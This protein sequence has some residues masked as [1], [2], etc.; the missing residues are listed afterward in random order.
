MLNSS[1]RFAAVVESA[2]RIMNSCVEY[3]CVISKWLNI[4]Y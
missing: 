2:T 1:Y 3:Y 4:S